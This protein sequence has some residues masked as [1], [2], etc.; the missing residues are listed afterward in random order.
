M[1]LSASQRRATMIPIYT[2]MSMAQVAP[3]TVQAS[4]PTQRLEENGLVCPRCGAG[5]LIKARKGMRAY[6]LVLH[7]RQKCYLYPLDK[8]RER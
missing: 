4:T 5:R 6:L 3:Q 1:T 8:V 7:G 2:P